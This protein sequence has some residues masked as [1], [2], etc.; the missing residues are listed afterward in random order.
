MN[1]WAP[2]DTVISKSFIPVIFRG[3]KKIIKQ[4]LQS[5]SYY[6]W[7]PT[8]EPKAHSDI[9][10]SAHRCCSFSCYESKVMYLG[11]SIC[12]INSAEMASPRRLIVAKEMVQE[13]SNYL[14]IQ[15]CLHWSGQLL[16]E[17]EWEKVCFQPWK[18]LGPPILAGGWGEST[19]YTAAAHQEKRKEL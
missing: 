14:G 8:H 15:T 16:Q 1:E 9:C 11:K 7:V 19:L 17:G 13:S 4:E 2:L 10:Q 18:K 6:S 3:T 12:K 5:W